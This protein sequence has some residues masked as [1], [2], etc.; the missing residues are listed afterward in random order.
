MKRFYLGSRLYLCLILLATLSGCQPATNP[1]SGLWKMEVD[2]DE[3]PMG[4]DS[5]TDRLSYVLDMNLAERTF[6]PE[7][8][9]LGGRKTYG[10]MDFSNFNRIYRYEIDSVYDLGGNRYRVVSV[11][12]NWETTSEDTLTYDPKTKDMTYGRD[13]V[14][15]YVPD[16]KPFDGAWGGTWE[17]GSSEKIHLSL[18]KKMKAPEDYPFEGAECY[19]YIIS[20]NEV[21]SS[22]KLITAVKQVHYDYAVVETVFPDYP[23]DAPFELRLSYKRESGNLLVGDYL[24]S[25]Y[26]PLEGIAPAI[27]QP[28]LPTSLTDVLLFVSILAALS[29]AVFFFRYQWD[30]YEIWTG[31]PLL[32]IQSVLVWWLAGD[33]LAHGLPDTAGLEG[34]DILQ[35]YLCVI[36]TG[37]TMAIGMFKQFEWF[38]QKETDYIT[39]PTLAAFVL[40][41]IPPVLVFFGG[42]VLLDCLR[43]SFLPSLL[44][45]QGTLAFIAALC[46]ALGILCIAGQLVLIAVG[47]RGWQRPMLVA[48]YAVTM[49]ATMLTLMIAVLSLIYLAIILLVIGL[50]IAI[51]RASSQSYRASF[52]GHVVDETGHKTRVTKV[53]Q[54]IFGDKHVTTEDGRKYG[55]AGGNEMTRED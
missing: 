29:F 2:T 1:P 37:V 30:K 22:Y 38:A 27:R 8:E 50:I 43:A 39:L 55:S 4:A 52:K 49:T 40:C 24:E 5:E 48:S 23:E 47:Q 42:D 10:R 51:M 13:W 7:S 36:L 46:L 17:D 28:S 54:G 16:L 26:P 3:A 20:D 21:E 14:F 34:S 12:V 11:D 44:F 41:A 15:H 19:G 32:W 35:L 53:E 31:L 18:Y 25:E 33:M 6:E 9:L 45:Q